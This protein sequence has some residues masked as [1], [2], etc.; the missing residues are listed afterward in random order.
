MSEVADIIQKPEIRDEL[1]YN[2]WK[3]D[4]EKNQRRTCQNKLARGVRG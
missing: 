4:Y 2:Y 3:A 1:K